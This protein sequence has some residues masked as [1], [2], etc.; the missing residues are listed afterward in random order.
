MGEPVIVVTTRTRRGPGISLFGSLGLGCQEIPAPVPLADVVGFQRRVITVGVPR[1][2]AAF[3]LQPLV[4][5]LLHLPAHP[6]RWRD[7]EVGI[8][9][10][11]VDEDDRDGVIDHD[12][13][14][15]ELPAPARLAPRDHLGHAVIDHQPR[16][17]ADDL[18]VPVSAGRMVDLLRRARPMPRLVILN[19]C[20]SAATGVGD[21]F[22]G[23]AAALV[24]GGAPPS[25][26]CSTRSPTAPRSRSPAASTPPSPA[27][28]EL[29]T[30][31]PA[32]RS[33]S[34]DSVTRPWNGSPP[35]LYLRG[36]ETR[37]FTLPTS[38]ADSSRDNTGTENTNTARRQLGGTINP[39]ATDDNPTRDR[40]VDHATTHALQPQ[41]AQ[42]D[43]DPR[44]RSDEAAADGS[45]ADD[46]SITRA[47][48]ERIRP[49][50]R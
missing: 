4:V 32:A 19:S 5:T 14:E 43:S 8:V 23:T 36:H 13:V 22:S 37:L 1:P 7:V 21:L 40:P 50:C 42:N 35:C 18:D 47:S 38:T 12:A 27:A 16:G 46:P 3:G 2:F 11:E 39:T 25:P 41:V 44:T 9:A 33:E 6:L 20:A 49:S 45:R 48:Q 26:R 15:A 34:S 30:R 29:L 10:G 28:G 31:S 17:S 24:R